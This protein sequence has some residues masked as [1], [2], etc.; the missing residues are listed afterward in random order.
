MEGPYECEQAKRIVFLLLQYKADP[1][2]KAY[3][4]NNIGVQLTIS[5]LGSVLN[6]PNS[7]GKIFIEPPEKMAQ[8]L[9]DNPVPKYK[10]TQQSSMKYCVALFA[11]K[12]PGLS[13][14]LGDYMETIGIPTTTHQLYVDLLESGKYSDI[15]FATK[16]CIKVRL[17]VTC[18]CVR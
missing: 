12:P 10:T 9:H 14:V 13:I 7:A 6:M 2:K 4:E 3:R 8:N 17:L 11:G 18:G 1:K 16:V 5:H 15:V